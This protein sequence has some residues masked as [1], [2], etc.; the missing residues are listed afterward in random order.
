VEIG[1]KAFQNN[2]V[3]QLHQDMSKEA[4]FPV[5][6]SNRENSQ[7]VVKKE[8][9]RNV[10]ITTRAKRDGHGSAGFCLVFV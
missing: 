6:E 4:I 8:R 3:G 2:A 7:Y 9:D 10:A 5:S 1:K